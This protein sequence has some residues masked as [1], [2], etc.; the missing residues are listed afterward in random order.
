M[1][2]TILDVI[3]LLLSPLVDFVNYFK[4]IKF[5]TKGKISRILILLM[6]LVTVFE[7]IVTDLIGFPPLDALATIIE[8]GLLILVCSRSKKDYRM[9]LTGALIIGIIDLGNNIVVSFFGKLFDMSAE[10]STVIYIFL[11]L[12]SYIFISYY[13]KKINKLISGRNK[14]ILLNSAI[15]LYISSLIAYI[16]ASIEKTLSTALVILIGILIIQGVYTI[17][18]VKIS[19]R[20]SKNILN[21][22]EQNYLKKQNAQLQRNN[23]QLKEYANSLEKDEDRLRRFKH[24]YR[25]ILNSLKISAQK[26]DSK[27]LIKQLD[28]YT[29][30]HFDSDALSKFKDVNHIHDEL[31]KSIIIT[32]LSKMFNNGIKYRF[33]CE[34]D[35]NTFPFLSS[36]E[37]MDVVRIL[38]ITFDNA[39]EATKKEKDPKIEAMLYQNNGNLEFII[40]NSIAKEINK[41]EVFQMGH[42]TKE[43]HSGIGLNNVLKIVEKYPNNMMVDINT[44]VGWFTFNLVIFK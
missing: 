15:Y 8:M 30:E 36:S 4:I 41:N 13:A 21:E 29:K 3:L 35:I 11:V 40:R 22:A 14:N 20:T 16:I 39:I 2:S 7:E 38:G 32:K 26:E 17:V 43:N 44:E 27:V 25:N 23:N 9:L 5:K 19:V 24:D 6:F 42:T 33:S 37:H 12:L 10:I 28:E 18:N 34:K 31:V 1:L